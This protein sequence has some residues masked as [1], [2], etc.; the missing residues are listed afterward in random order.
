V[1][2]VYVSTENPG[3]SWAGISTDSGWPKLLHT[4]DFWLHWTDIT[5]SLAPV[6]RVKAIAVTPMNPKQIFVGTEVGVFRSIDGG[7]TWAPF[8]DGL[9][10]VQVTD[11]Y[12]VPDPHRSGTDQLVV[13]TYGRGVYARPIAGSPLTYVD[14]NHVGVED[15]MF[16]NPYDTIPEGIADTPTAGTLALRGDDHLI[17]SPLLI[18]SRMLIRSYD[19]SARIG[20]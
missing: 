8:Q 6:K 18:N 2:Q 17:A 14:P 3:E 19:G 7:A 11:V 4:T 1:D 5:G 15:G 13:S 16:T 10:V 20:G 9:P 12:Y